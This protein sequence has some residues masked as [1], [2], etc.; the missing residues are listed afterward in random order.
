[1]NDQLNQL[2]QPILQQDAGDNNQRHLTLGERHPV[3]YLGLMSVYAGLAY[4]WLLAFPLLLIFLVVSIPYSLMHAHSFPQYAGVALELLAA[5]VAA[6][7]SYAIYKLPV[8]Y[9]AGRP[10]QHDEAPGLR[11]LI[12][13]LCNKHRA[14]HIDRIRIVRELAM[15]LVYTP[16]NGYPFSSSSNLLIGLPLM[17]SLSPRYLL[18]RIEREIVKDAGKY[19]RASAWICLNRKMCHQYHLAW[20]DSWSVPGLFMRAMFSWYVPLFKILSISACRMQQY[21]ADKKLQ[22]TLSDT[23]LVEMLVTENICGH[24]LTNDFWPHLYSKA[25]RHKQP[26]YLPYSSL[27]HNLRVKLDQ[28]NAQSWL[29]ADLEQST[30][31]SF[32]PTLRQRLSRLGV[33]R[34]E[35][36]P[37]VTE[38]A[39]KY[40]L[41][42]NLKVIASQLDR[43]WLKAHEFEWQQKYQQ[44]LQQQQRLRHLIMH[45]MQ[46]LLTEETAWELLQLGKRHLADEQMYPLYRQVMQNGLSDA[47]IYFDI[48]RN[49]LGHFDGQGVVALEKAMALDESYTVIACQLMTKYFVHIGNS[50]SAQNYRRRAL[51]FQVNAA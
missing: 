9:P 27:D 28:Y 4:V 7:S 34:V 35:L 39:A 36:P 50:K 37:P 38:S 47:R 14:P 32:V 51:A 5:A 49:L 8:P 33:H 13:E 30:T 26:P 10:L 43:V 21:Y 1:M 12:N 15:D 40:F 42:N 3:I 41:A 2:E 16:E 46:K 20:K 31:L 25:Y 23:T 48:G 45:A 29:N 6:W 24:Y 11:N 17:Q 22:K 18:A 19:K 44:G